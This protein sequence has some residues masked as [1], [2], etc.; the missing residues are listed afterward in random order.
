MQ[1]SIREVQEQMEEQEKM[2]QDE[3]EQIEQQEQEQTEAVQQADDIRAREEEIAEALL[4]MVE[5]GLTREQGEQT[6]ED[7]MK[8]VRT[9][10]E[11]STKL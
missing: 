2:E 7:L 5:A 11:E 9:L 10:E 1:E 3:Q 8:H 4:S 6:E